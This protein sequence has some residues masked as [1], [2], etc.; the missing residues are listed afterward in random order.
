MWHLAPA[1]M[2]W[3]GLSPGELCGQLKDPE[4]NGNRSV[5]EVVRHMREDELVAWGWQPGTGREPVPGDQEI[6]GEL[7]AAWAEAGAVCPK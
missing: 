3:E 2:A 4:R 7:M 5:K 1:K 6:L